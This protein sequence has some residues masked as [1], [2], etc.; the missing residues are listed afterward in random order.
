MTDKEKIKQEIESYKESMKGLEPHSD[1][2]RGQ[3]TAYN[4]IMQFIDSLS[5]EPSVKGITWEDVNTLESLIYQVHNEYPSIGEKSFGLEV[6]ERFQD[7]QDSIE[8]PANEDLEEEIDRYYSDWQFDDDTIYEDMRNICR[9]FA[10]W[11][12]QQM[13]KDAVNGTVCHRNGNVGDIYFQ[14][15]SVLS[16]KYQFKY[17]ERIKIIIIK[18]NML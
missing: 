10:E 14:S 12:K 5:E 7:C 1:F 8:E 4:Q 13:I 3:I 2:R 16:A 17:G 9:H 18:E 6:L 11:Q 15:D